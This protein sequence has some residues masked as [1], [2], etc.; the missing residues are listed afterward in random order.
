[1]FDIY[2][3]FLKLMNIKGQNKLTVLWHTPNRVNIK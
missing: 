1:M 3:V 2:L